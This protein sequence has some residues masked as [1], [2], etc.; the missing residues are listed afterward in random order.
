MAKHDPLETVL[1]LALDA[2]EAAATQLRGV[3]LTL[4]KCRQQLDAL[5]QYRLD[6]MK[7]MEAQQ[8]QVIAASSYHQFHQFIRQIDE[9]IEKQVF[10]VSETDKQRQKAQQYWQGKQQKRKAVELL[11]AH[12]AEAKQKFEAKQE[13]KMIDE[14]AS[15]QFFRQST[16]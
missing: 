7:Q 1:K 10:A 11:L 2:E 15:Q 16:R 4:N 5:Q 3:Q 13:Q 8:G 6:Y 9:A 12:K 14:F